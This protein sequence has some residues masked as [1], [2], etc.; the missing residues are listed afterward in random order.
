M[1]SRSS[2]RNIK[3]VSQSS[4]FKRKPLQCRASWKTPVKE[5][6]IDSRT[7]SVGVSVPHEFF[8]ISLVF[9]VL[10]WGGVFVVC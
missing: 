6:K 4:L 8:Y 7:E 3:A 10:F 5:L 2:R 9:S 1:D